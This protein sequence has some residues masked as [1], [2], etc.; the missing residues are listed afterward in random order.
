MNRSKTLRIAGTLGAAVALAAALEGT[1]SA[2]PAWSS[3]YPTWGDAKC[4][5]PTSLSDSKH[6]I[7]TCLRYDSNW[8][9]PYTIVMNSNSSDRLLPKSQPGYSLLGH[10]VCD[11]G[12]IGKQSTKYCLGPKLSLA[13]GCNSWPAYTYYTW[14]TDKYQYS[15]EVNLCG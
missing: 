9:E 7:I 6:V 12:G 13:K 1:A 14:Y 4:S 2:A 5:S 3:S 11:A 10:S 8:A 15:P